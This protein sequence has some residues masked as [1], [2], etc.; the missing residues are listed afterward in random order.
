MSHIS[1]PIIYQPLGQWLWDSL[2]LFLFDELVL[3]LPGH[4]LQLGEV[5]QRVSWG[6]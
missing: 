3:E 4:D 1:C 2:Y 6:A 5:L